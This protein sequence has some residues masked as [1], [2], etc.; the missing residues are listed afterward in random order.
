MFL[1]SYS[2]DDSV[3][4][5]REVVIRGLVVYLGEKEENLFQEQLVG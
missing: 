1:S 5:R 2:Q 4:M 3:E